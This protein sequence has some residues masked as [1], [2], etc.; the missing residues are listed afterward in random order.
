ML[1]QGEMVR[2]AAPYQATT[3]GEMVRQ[4]APYQA[5][6]EIYDE[7]WGEREPERIRQLRCAGE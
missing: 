2:Q 5:D 3:R 6:V 4:A 7:S 1:R